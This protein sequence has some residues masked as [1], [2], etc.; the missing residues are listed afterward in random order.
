MAE[1]SHTCAGLDSQRVHHPGQG[2]RPHFPEKGPRG[3]LQGRIL[4][5]S[6]QLDMPPIPGTLS[7][8]ISMLKLGAVS[9]Q[10]Q[11]MCVYIAL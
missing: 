11:I 2:S 8:H 5:S 6:E 3:V 1:A 10:N 4:G 7:P 9:Q